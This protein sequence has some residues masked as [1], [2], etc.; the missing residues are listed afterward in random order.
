M[1][2]VFS[3]IHGNLPALE[4]CY[5]DA[6]ARGCTAFVNLGDIV[7]GP[8]W[9]RETADWLMRHDWPTL[10]GNHERQLLT[11]P[12]GR[13]GVS[14]RHALAELDSVHLEWLRSL[15]GDLQW[16]GSLY[17]CHANPDDDIH[18]LLHR[19]GPDGARDAD[20]EEIAAMLGARDSAVIGCGH[21]HM[22]RHIVLAGGRQVFNPGS[23]GLPAY[24]WD[25][26]FP[27]VMELGSVQARYAVLS[28]SEQGW[29]IDLVGVDYD[30]E[31]AATRAEQHGR[32][33]WA[34][35]LRTGFVG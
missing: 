29:A 27:H 3:D 2:A 21:S 10:A 7:S 22:P 31:A 26:P 25:Y 30:H 16:D 19:V 1:I 14:D 5:R 12:P 15:P 11:D 32:I 6:L 13:M 23:V 18:Y 9:P 17:F 4:A 8:L 28:Q 24:E 35:P 20:A 34:V 33:D